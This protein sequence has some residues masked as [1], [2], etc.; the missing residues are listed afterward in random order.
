MA[1]DRY[2]VGVDGGASKTVALI[3][4]E[5]GKILGRGESG[6]SNYHN[7]GAAAAGR[8]IKSAVIE[9]QRQANLRGVRLEIA[10]VALAAVDSEKDRS[11]ARGFVR[12]AKIARTSFVV[13]DS[14]AALYAATKGKPGIIVISGT[15]C[16]AAG[17][18]RAGE[19]VRAG[20]WGYLIDDEGSAFD[21][22]RKGLMRAFRMLDG[23]APSTKLISILKRKFGVRKLED[24]LNLIYAEGMSV[25]EI[26]RLA[27][28]ISKAAS[29]DRACKE[30]LNNAGKALAALACV[31]ARR[32]HMTGDSFEVGTVGGNFKSGRH[33]FEPFVAG[34]RKECQ[35][36]RVV[37]LR[38]EPA[39]GALLLASSALSN[40]NTRRM[41][42][43]RAY[44]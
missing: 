43:S 5:S 33:L 14:V 13:H 15:G 30:I 24:A 19:Y 36:A 2:V 39:L 7:I 29:R 44:K 3:G 1:T 16:V 31:V 26:A 35:R 41:N 34:I 4:T 28:L 23:R 27:P 11:K 18:N 9:A 40:R 12:T 17:I 22:G 21:I 20:G 10:V 25:E 42:N 38:V 6:P 32:L 8:A 37:K